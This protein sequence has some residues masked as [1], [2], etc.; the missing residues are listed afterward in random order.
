LASGIL[1]TG[2]SGSRTFKYFSTLFVTV[3]MG[4]E[5]K[6]LGA[7]TGLKVGVVGLGMMMLVLVLLYLVF[8]PLIK[9]LLVFLA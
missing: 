9:Y 1:K 4:W 8:S 6:D 2:A 3:K 5:E 7:T